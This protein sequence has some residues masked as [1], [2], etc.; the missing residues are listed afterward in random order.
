MLG[1]ARLQV[2]KLLLYNRKEIL[3]LLYKL[4][5]LLCIVTDFGITNR[6]DGS[7]STI[8]I[9]DVAHILLGLC[10]DKITTK[11]TL[12]FYFK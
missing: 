1:V 9:C 12:H 5:Y 6:I 3:K 11:E 8:V 10:C 2:I 7:A 4:L